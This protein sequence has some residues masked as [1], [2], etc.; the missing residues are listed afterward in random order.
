[1][2]FEVFFDETAEDDLDA[3]YRTTAASAGE[4][5]AGR[6]IGRIRNLCLS[7]SDFPRRGRPREDLGPGIRTLV[8]GGRVVIGYEIEGEAVYIV[9][10]I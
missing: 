10:V 7:L 5:T 9:H 8:F 1:M 2:K 6:F 4:R 3:L